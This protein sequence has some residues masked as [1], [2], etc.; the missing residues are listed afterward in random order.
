[1]PG[2]GP[3]PLSRVVAI[4]ARHLG[5]PVKVRGAGPWMLRLASLFV[6]ELR[7]FMP[8]APTYLQPIAFDGTKL[9][10]L[11]GTLPTTPYEEGIP[12]TLDGLMERP[13]PSAA[14]G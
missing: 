14:Q 2:A 4:V 1:V 8:M 12:H 10:S 3:I 9:R 6:G 11:L 7:A 5:R 13:V